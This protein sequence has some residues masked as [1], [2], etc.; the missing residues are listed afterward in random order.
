MGDNNLALW[1]ATYLAIMAV[2]DTL[3]AKQQQKLIRNF[4]TLAELRDKAGD[5]VASCFLHAL[6]G[7][8]FVEAERP[9]GTDPAGSNKKPRPNY[10]KVI[11]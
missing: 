8:R 9:T 5:T 4:R 3:S 1:D 10:L 6:A 11:K 2:G 7:D